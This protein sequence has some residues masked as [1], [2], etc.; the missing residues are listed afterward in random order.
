MYSDPHVSR[1]RLMTFCGVDLKS[2]IF[3]DVFFGN[4]GAVRLVGCY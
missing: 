4:G 2:G 1:G 3:I